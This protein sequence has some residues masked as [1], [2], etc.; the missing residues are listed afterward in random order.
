MAAPAVRPYPVDFVRVYERVG[1]YAEAAPR[2]AGVLPWQKAPV[3]KIAVE[4]AVAE[5]AATAKS[6]ARSTRK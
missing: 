6:V 2:G 3:K 5:K 4:K 1:G